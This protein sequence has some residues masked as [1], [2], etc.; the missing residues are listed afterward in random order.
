[1]AT[2]FGS[3][4]A[5]D[6]N[7]GERLWAHLPKHEGYSTDAWRPS[8]V[9]AT[10]DHLYAVSRQGFVYTVSMAQTS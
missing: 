5:L 9:M 8:P 10:R 2:G 4:V 1:M 3:V 6:A 7:S